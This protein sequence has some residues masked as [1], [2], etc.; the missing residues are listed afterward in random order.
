MDRISTAN[1]TT[2]KELII[3]QQALS[4]LVNQHPLAQCACNRTVRPRFQGDLPILWQRLVWKQA[5]KIGLDGLGI[6]GQV[7]KLP[8]WRVGEGKLQ[9]VRINR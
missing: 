3:S 2:G 1:D 5:A 7:D 8:Q 9:V 6:R 4:T